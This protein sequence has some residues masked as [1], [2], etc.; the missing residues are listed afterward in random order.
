MEQKINTNDETLIQNK[1]ITSSAGPEEAVQGNNARNAA[2]AGV[3]GAALGAAGA[4]GV[5]ALAQG[6]DEAVTAPEPAP[7]PAPESAPAP[8]PAPEPAPAPA[9]APEPDPEPIADPEH[10]AD[11]G[12]NAD[13]GH[14]GQIEVL[15][16]QTGE[17]EGNEV[18]VA[19]V[20][21]DGHDG[22]LV[23]VDPG[24]E[25]MGNHE[26][27]V[28]IIDADDSGTIED[29]EIHDIR[30]AGLT[31]EDAVIA[32]AARQEQGEE[33]YASHEEDGPD[34]FMEDDLTMDGG[35]DGIDDYDN[36]ADVEM[37]EA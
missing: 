16:V 10:V 21:V 32:Q 26:F 33:T 18:I 22:I 35:V 24:Q 25:S 14:E 28:A 12:S 29:H 13:P 2:A 36:T 6:T 15:T 17:I 19:G 27:D 34:P 20:K 1:N 7:A 5:N 3:G 37:Y 30:G 8:V 31:A 11:P 23:D 9:P 4:Y